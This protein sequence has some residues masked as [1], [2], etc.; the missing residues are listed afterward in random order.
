MMLKNLSIGKKIGIGFA[1]VLAL[2]MVVGAAGYMALTKVSDGMAVYREINSVNRNFTR[3][4]DLTNRYM[5]FSYEEGREQQDAA[6]TDV[7]DYIGRSIEHIKQIMRGLS[8]SDIIGQQLERCEKE[9][10]NYQKNF[11][12]YATSENN[13]IKLEQKIHRLNTGLTEL[14]RKATFMADEMQAKTDVAAATSKV[15]FERNTDRRRVQFEAAFTGMKAAISSWTKKTSRSEQLRGIGEKLQKHVAEYEQHLLEYFEEVRAQQTIMASMETNQQTLGKVFVNLD[16]INEKNIRS[17]EKSALTVIFGVVAASLIF[18]VIFALNFGPSLAKRIKVIEEAVHRIAS[19]DLDNPIQPDGRDELGRLAED[20]EA[21]RT[22]IIKVLQ[23]NE[24]LI[25]AIQNGH[26]NTR[27]NAEVYS[28]AWRDLMRS[29]NNVIDAFMTPFNLTAENIGRIADGDIPEPIEEEYKGGFNEIR[30]NLNTMINNLVRFAVDVQESSEQVATKSEQLSNSAAQVS[31]GTAQQSAGIE[32]ISSSM[33]QM[34]SMVNQ[35][36]DNARQTARMADTAS[37]DAH[38]CAQVLNETVQAM[39]IIS[40]KILV[41]EDISNQTNLL[42]LNASIEAARAMEHGR[43]FAVVATEVRDLAKNTRKA[44]Q[45][46]NTLSISGIEIAEK[47]GKML[48]EMVTGIRKTA[49]LVQEISAS[50]TEQAGGISEVNNAVQQFDHTIQKN[51]ASTEQMASS[52]KDFAYQAERLLEISSFFKISEVV[53][54]RLKKDSEPQLDVEGQKLL[55]DMEAMPESARKAMVGYMRKMF[56]SFEN[57]MK[58]SEPDGIN[59]S[60]DNEPDD[61]KEEGRNAESEQMKK[62]NDSRLQLENPD[63]NEFEA[64]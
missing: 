62:K 28:G 2:M 48:E 16:Q 20:T 9:I 47:T 7:M 52:S 14:T 12:N 43:G 42:A 5:L 26:L 22:S 24:N 38:K 49:E 8:K 40:E 29:I 64:Y 15:F 33:E 44:A 36:A 60:K 21:M 6:Y 39:K 56:Q 3:V 19:G 4:L 30:N 37:S 57:Q 11:S 53:R 23:E 31:Q 35:S 25:H 51:A 27:G 32:E 63:D 59:P 17:V 10:Q 41:I 45:D 61:N 54:E 18:G 34:S 55:T 58:E 1:L 13:K 50:S 46:I